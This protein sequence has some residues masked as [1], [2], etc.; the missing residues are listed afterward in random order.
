MALTHLAPLRQSGPPQRLTGSR[1]AHEFNRL[2]GDHLEGACQLARYLTSDDKCRQGA[3][4]EALRQAFREFESYSGGSPRA[5]LFAI[6][7]NHCRAFE[8]GVGGSV[9]LVMRESALGGVSGVL[10]P[11]GSRC[12]RVLE[13]ALSSEHEYGEVKLVITAIPEPFREPVV[14]KELQHL[15]PAEIAE[16]TGLPVKTVMARLA[17]GRWLVDEELLALPSYE[18][19]RQGSLG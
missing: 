5:W 12:G 11:A 9:S 16:V 8:A 15:S 14:L 2:F 19:W 7:R 13:A 3:I 18:P 1:R 17:I 10:T 4:D 6:V